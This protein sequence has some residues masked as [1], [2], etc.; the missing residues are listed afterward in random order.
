MRTYG[1]FTNLSVVHKEAQLQ[2]VQYALKVLWSPES[3]QVF[4][5]D[6]IVLPAAAAPCGQGVAY[7]DALTV[8]PLSSSHFIPPKRSSIQYG[9][10]TTCGETENVLEFV[11]KW[12]STCNFRDSDPL[13][14]PGFLG[15]AKCRRRVRQSP[16]LCNDTRSRVMLG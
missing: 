16:F 5:I 13:L 4:W 2:D 8:R 12:P 14:Q 11:R 3:F 9:R 15:I 1:R 7:L 10:C 6:I